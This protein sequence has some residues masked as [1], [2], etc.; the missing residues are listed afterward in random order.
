MGEKVERL[1]IEEGMKDAYLT[2]AMSVIVSRALPDVRDGLKPSQRRILVAMNDLNLTPR[3]KFRK[4][5]KICGDTSGNYH[6]H[7]EEVIYPT[8]VRMAQDFNMRYILIEGQGNFGSIDGDPPA[9]MRY[10]EARM[11]PAAVEMLED[12]EKDTVDF[13]PNY[14]E[15]RTEPRVLPA[16]FP[17]LLV[18]GAGG[19]AVGM[20]TNIPPH[21]LAEV[22]DA[23]VMLIDE[24]D[25]S[26]DKLL[27]VLPGPDFPTGG[28]ICGTAG[29]KEAYKTGKGKIT[30]RAKTCFEKSKTGREAIVVTEIPFQVTKTRIIE[31]M[32][33]LV[34]D[35]TLKGIADIRDE[36][37][38]EGI[39]L[40]IEIKKGENPQVVLNQLYKHGVL[41]TTFGIILIALHNNRPL[42][43]SIK[44]L[45]QCYID[46]RFEI[47]TRRTQYLLDK[48]NERLHIVK[49][50]LIALASIDDV[51][52]TIK[53]SRTTEEARERLMAQFSLTEPQTNAILAMQLS[54]LVG[55]EKE[56]L[57]KE[58]DD[59][60][61]KIKDYWHILNKKEAVYDIIKEDLYDLK[62]K[63][64]DA[65]RTQILDQEPEEITL[66][67]IVPEHE[68]AVTV[69]HQ[70]YIKQTPLEQYR[71]QGRGGKGVI[72][73][74]M[75]EE[76]FVEHMYVCS[77]HDWLLVFTNKGKLYWLRVLEIPQGARDSKGRSISN[78]L[79]ISAEDRIEQII[80]V[81]QFDKRPLFFV[82]R[83]G[84][85]KKTLLSNFSRPTKAGIIAIA[86]KKGD[87]LVDV[88][89][90]SGNDEIVLGTKDG[91][92]IRFAE[93][94]VRLMGRNAA[95]V[96]GITLREGDAVC[97]A[98]CVEKD[99]TL[100]TVFDNGI[101]KRTPF[102]EYRIQK[103]GGKG[104]INAK[105]P[106]G[107]K[108][109]TLL[110]AHDEDELML[111]SAGGKMIR[112]GVKSIRQTGRATKGVWLMRL[113]KGDRL[114][115][116]ARIERD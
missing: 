38:R 5:A 16:K 26:V 112:T 110:A 9:A 82:T 6:P 64:G 21:N 57:M 4:C 109:V 13:D 69:T 25:V 78:L 34:K 83:Q 102:K 31:R 41:Q 71:R 84:Y 37:D 85:V 70:R 114:V 89:V 107:V 28:I 97:G 7:G 48:A 96:K 1:L 66:E 65:R 59:L 92:A 63:Y 90:T 17:N 35:E 52:A 88:L 30:L 86:L 24:P 47:V 12:M 56:K 75:K 40:V 68:V 15:T 80:A 45:M 2:Y 23:I 44:E 42:T 101:G 76:D 18:N 32:V 33:E 11:A 8:L 39:R 60:N 51:I 10:T 55:L 87:S 62:E 98:V 19:I 20:A 72:G 106:K 95:G 77:S 79:S 91:F 27:K 105:L 53:T 100:L 50:L 54:R 73:T 22:V 49:G 111:I 14:D 43:M 74:D 116:V 108:V 103:R 58:H 94:D 29:I 99:G 93:S 36:S 113:D 67:D 81:R 115:S 3:A 104:I 61:Q 46:H